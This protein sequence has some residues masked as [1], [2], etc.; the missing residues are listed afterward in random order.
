VELTPGQKAAA[1]KRASGADKLAGQKAA[2]TRR[3]NKA[4]AEQE[5]LKIARARKHRAKIRAAAKA[6][7]AM[8]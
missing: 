6:A 8:A 5:A 3:A 4:L 7:L 1:T 2:A